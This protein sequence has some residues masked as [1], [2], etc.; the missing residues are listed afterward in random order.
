MIFTFHA[1]ATIFGSLLLVLICNFQ[2]YPSNMLNT[3][4]QHFV[5]NGTRNRVRVDVNKPVRLKWNI[6]FVH[7]GV[8]FIVFALCHIVSVREQA[9]IHIYGVHLLFPDELKYMKNQQPCPYYHN[10]LHGLHKRN[11]REHSSLDVFSSVDRGTISPNSP[12]SR[13][14]TDICGRLIPGNRGILAETELETRILTRILNI[15]EMD[16]QF[17]VKCRT[18][19]SMPHLPKRISRTVQF[20]TFNTIYSQGELLIPMWFASSFGAHLR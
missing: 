3:P 6:F 11:Y 14:R 13:S 4:E 5:M 1:L 15:A 8:H 18:Q 10:F 2:I 12:N 20:R 17:F 19:R 16:K 7:S 9:A